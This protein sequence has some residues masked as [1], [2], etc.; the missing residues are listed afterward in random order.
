MKD[1]GFTVAELLAAL[2]VLSLGMAFLGEAIY[3]ESRSWTRQDEKARDIRKLEGL[4]SAA[5]A[6]ETVLKSGAPLGAGPVLAIDDAP[7]LELSAPRIDQTASCR[8]DP[9]GRR[10][11]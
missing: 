1:E 10:C 3:R 2:V 11:R 6:S 4:Y 9:I 7:P 5:L 8:F